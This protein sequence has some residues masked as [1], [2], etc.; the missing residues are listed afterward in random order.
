MA[1]LEDGADLHGEGL[2]AVLALVDADAGAFALEL[3]D[4]IQSTAAWADTGPFGRKC[5]STQS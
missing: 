3:G 5:T 1:V 2:A 4:P